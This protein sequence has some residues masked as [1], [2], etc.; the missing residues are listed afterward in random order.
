VEHLARAV[1]DRGESDAARQAAAGALAAI[2][3]EPGGAALA[4]VVMDPME[5]TVGK[6][7]ADEHYV[8]W[9]AASR[10]TN[11]F[12]SPPEI[13]PYLEGLVNDTWHSIHVRRQA[14]HGIGAVKSQDTVP[15]LQRLLENGDLH[16]RQF[17]IKSMGLTHDHTLSA[18]LVDLLTSARTVEERRDVPTALGELGATDAVPGLA[19]SLATDG[20]ETVRRNAATALVKLGAYDAVLAKLTDESERLSVRLAALSA[21]EDAGVKAASVAS[22]VQSLMDH[23]HGHIAFHARAAH[24]ALMGAEFGGV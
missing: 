16:V 3:L 8:Y 18:V 20:D 23:E 7:G 24:A 12:N 5:L 21:L 10:A 15:T 11:A 14:P 4:A 1:G 6:I 17:T 2:G 13:L 22:T 9:E 19:E